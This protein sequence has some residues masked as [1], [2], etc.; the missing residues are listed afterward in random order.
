MKIIT[1]VFFLFAIVCVALCN[2]APSDQY[3]LTTPLPLYGAYLSNNYAGELTNI[4]A[5]NTVNTNF[6]WFIEAEVKD[7]S[8]APVYRFLT[9]GPGCSSL[10]AMLLEIGPYLIREYGQFE[11]NDWRLTKFANVLIMDSPAYVGFSTTSDPG[12]VW[13]DNMTAEYN[14]N[15]MLEFFK[16][17][18][19]FK[20]SP[21]IIGGES[22]G[23]R[24]GP[25]LVDAILSGP[26]LAMKQNLQAMAIG[27]P[28]TSY[29]GCGNADPTLIPY[30]QGQ[31]FFPFAENVPVDPNANYNP[32]DLLVPTCPNDRTYM[33]NRHM[34]KNHPVLKAYGKRRRAMFGASDDG[35]AAVAADGPAVPPYGPCAQDVMTGWLNR[36]DVKSILHAP[37]AQQFQIC[38]GGRYNATNTTMVPLYQKF[39]QE[40]PTLKMMIYSGLSDSIVNQLNSQA[41]VKEMGF[42]LV[43][44]ELQAWY[45]PY[46]RNASQSQLGGFFLQY[47]SIV[48]AGVTK[49]GHEVPLY[50]P[51]KFYALITDFYTNGKPNHNQFG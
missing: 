43:K 10:F 12:A 50:Q 27:N 30:L 44:P 15:S 45:Y 18:P 42:A 41:S 5:G 40:R 17:F 19:Q 24:Y 28:C 36:A 2:A 8:T 49:S 9:G 6:F 3:K 14:Y 39:A 26:D 51:D 34:E 33:M 11:L 21:L 35:A 22:W 31:G 1:A 37:P 13:D 23:G 7:P 4:T 25:T 20:T 47:N 29:V 32:Y 16:V 46:T 48:W 38:G